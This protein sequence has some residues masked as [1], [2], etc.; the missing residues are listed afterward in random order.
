[1]SKGRFNEIKKIADKDKK[2]KLQ[3][4]LLEKKVIS[5]TKISSLIKRINSL[6]PTQTTL[7]KKTYEMYQSIHDD[8]KILIDTILVTEMTPSR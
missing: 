6:D 4:K 2:D 1:M 3:V 7:D 8:S 5:I